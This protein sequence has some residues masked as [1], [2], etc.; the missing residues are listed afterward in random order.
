MPSVLAL[1]Q[2]TTG[3]TALVI[4]AE[5]RVVARAYREFTQHFPK[6]GWVEHDASEIWQVTLD[7]AREALAQVEETPAAIGITNQRETVVAW[8]RTSGQP[9]ARALVWQDRRTAG[10]CRELRAERG[11]EWIAQRTGLVWDPYFSGTKIEWLLREV[12]EVRKAAV[13]GRAAFGTID[14]WLIYQFTSGAAH[15]TDHTNASRTLLYDIGAQ[16]WDPDLL[17]LFGVPRESLPSIGRSS[18]VVGVADPSHLGAE[19]PIAG[20]AGDQQAALFG[21]GCWEP[22]Q[23]KNTYGTGAFLLMVVGSEWRRVQGAAGRERGAGRGVLTT[24]ACDAA[25]APTFA[26]EG[27]I[28]IAG[29]AL[30][31]LRDGLGIIERAADSEKLAAAVTDTGGVY[32]VPAFVGL[33]APHWEPEARGTIVGLTRGSSRAHLVRA[34]LEAMAFGTRDVLEAM[35]DASGVPLTQLKVDGGAAANDWLMQFQTDTL[36]VRVARPDVVETTALGAAGLAGL[37]TG[38]WRNAEEFLA[39][40]SYRW[41]E[42]AARRDVEYREWRR[43]VDTALSWA[44]ARPDAP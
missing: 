34:A 31:W 38:V 26:L 23:A 44:R 25:G 4:S 41:F 42:P 37:A 10:R 16:D 36:G 28:F 29:A 8:D 2:G 22:G 6:P 30:Q 12:P 27:S 14:S 24:V 40:R 7:V 3:S 35:T 13:E 19:L 20:I 18:G 5:G 39:N 9:L 43:A 17:A 21:Q 1:D 15:V 32:F 33:G 11:D